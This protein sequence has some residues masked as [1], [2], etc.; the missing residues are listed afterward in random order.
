MMK[1]A[2]RKLS[3]TVHVITS[4]GWIGAIAVFLALGIVGVTSP[5]EQIVRAVYRVMLPAA[6]VVL[7]P[8]AFASLVSGIV[9]SLATAWGLFRHYWVIFKIVITVFSTVILMIYMQTF[10]A[11][12]RIAADATAAIQS[13]RN[14]SPIVHA[15]LAML[16]LTVAAV[17]GIY[18]PRGLTRYGWRKE[19]ERMD[20]NSP[21]A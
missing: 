8:L 17:L 16:L 15:A 21:V 13:V 10:D 3:L 12:S 11:M 19:H 18:K 5:D 2:V 14:P 7:L 6:R 9:E 1:P 20:H 4:V